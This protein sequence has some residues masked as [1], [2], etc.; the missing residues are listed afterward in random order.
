VGSVLEE[1]IARAPATNWVSVMTGDRADPRPTGPMLIE[2]GPHWAV[3]FDADLLV[4]RG[5][6]VQTEGFHSYLTPKTWVC[7]RRSNPD[8]VFEENSLRLWDRTG[9]TFVI[10][11]D[12][13]LI[14]AWLAVLGWSVTDP[15][16]PVFAT[17]YIDPP[18]WPLPHVGIAPT[19]AY[20]TELDEIE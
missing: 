17:A 5:Q 19:P 13:R 14:G 16:D 15:P 10:Q 12:G 3:A 4:H 11:P 18:P 2:R 8:I 6:I 9:D 20:L 7:D 1:E